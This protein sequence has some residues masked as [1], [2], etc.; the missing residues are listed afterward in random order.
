MS[1]LT[2]WVAMAPHP[3]YAP[4]RC[5]GSGEGPARWWE[6]EG[7]AEAAPGRAAEIW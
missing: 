4:S 3:K 1:V 7:P 2:A 5:V 6:R